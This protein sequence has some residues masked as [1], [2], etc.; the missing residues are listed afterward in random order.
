MPIPRPT[1]FL[2]AFRNLVFIETGSN[3]GDG[4]QAA[5]D[6]GFR[7]IYSVELSLFAFGYCTA[8]FKDKRKLVHLFQGDSRQFLREILPSV[9]TKITFWLDAHEC[10]SG[11]GDI[12]DCP[13]LEELLLISSHEI[14]E[15]TILIDDVRL[16]GTELPSLEIIKSTL[17][18]INPTYNIFRVDSDSF[19]DDILAAH[20]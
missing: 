20:P 14:K 9:T 7:C 4:I 18:G 11:V 8:R 10:G 5:L 1:P 6:A 12:K 16:F 13:L 15:H 17:L 3:Q 19:S 2:T